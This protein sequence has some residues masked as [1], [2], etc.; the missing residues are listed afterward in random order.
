M[1]VQWQNSHQT[2]LFIR[3]KSGETKK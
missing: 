1:K 3:L 2:N